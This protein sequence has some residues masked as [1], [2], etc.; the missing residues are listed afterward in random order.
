MSLKLS[1]DSMRNKKRQFYTA[2]D[3]IFFNKIAP[4][5]EKVAEFTRSTNQLK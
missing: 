3:K 1:L 2:L 4:Y 5:L